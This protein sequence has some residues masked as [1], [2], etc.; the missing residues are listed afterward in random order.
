MSDLVD[1]EVLWFEVA[2]QDVVAVTE[3]ETSQ[4][5]VQEALQ[6]ME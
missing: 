6:Q 3:G 5:L 1:E 2:V 4:Q